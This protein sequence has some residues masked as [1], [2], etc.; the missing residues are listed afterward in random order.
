[1]QRENAH[2]LE[3]FSYIIIASRLLDEQVAQAAV[4][5]ETGACA[6]PRLPASSQPT[7]RI[8][9][10]VSVT[11]GAFTLAFLLR[12]S[13]NAPSLGVGRLRVM[14]VMAV[15]AVF[16]ALGYVYVRSCWLDALRQQAIDLAAGLTTNLHSLET[17]TASA[18]TLVQE[19]ELVSRGYRMWVTSP[20]QSLLSTQEK[21]IQA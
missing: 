4:V 8:V 5:P 10:V 1:M 15:A 19:V 7:N 9:G 2:F 6:S 18:L 13:Q 3:H 20:V 11:L 21:R 14:V 17:S 16:A 12:W